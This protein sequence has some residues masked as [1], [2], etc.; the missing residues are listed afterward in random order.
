MID[1]RF[2]AAAFDTAGWNTESARK[3]CSSLNAEINAQL[4]A[5]LVPEMRKIVF[6][7]NEIGHTLLDVSEQMDDEMH[8]RS[9][10]SPAPDGEYKFLVA[11]DLVVTVGFPHA[12]RIFEF[13]PKD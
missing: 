10:G 9:F 6:R 2:S 8:F 1:E 7:L 11:A 12:P 13:E 5:V 4:L 3:L